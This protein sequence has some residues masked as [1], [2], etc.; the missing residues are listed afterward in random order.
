MRK[1]TGFVAATIAASAFSFLMSAPTPASA[2]SH[3]MVE[4]PKVKAR[5]ALGKRRAFTESWEFLSSE[6]KKRTG[7]NFELKLYYGE[8]LSKE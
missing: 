7:G 5:I 2:G 1:T 3:K 6:V 8:Q 4:G